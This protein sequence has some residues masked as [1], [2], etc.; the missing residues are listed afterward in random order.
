MDPALAATAWWSYAE[1]N[2]SVLMVVVVLVAVA[3]TGF[4]GHRIAS[5]VRQH[6]RR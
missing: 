2:R 6:K 5:V 3:A 4:V 1:G